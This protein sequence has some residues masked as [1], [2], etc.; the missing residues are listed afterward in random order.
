[1]TVTHLEIPPRFGAHRPSLF[2]K[3]L[4]DAIADALTQ[5]FPHGRRSAVRQVFKLSDDEARG[6]LRGSLSWETFDKVLDEGGWALA[7]EVL[8]LRFGEGLDQ[9]LERERRRHAERAEQIGEV[10]RDFRS[11]VRG[12]LGHVGGDHLRMASDLGA[13]HGDVG[14]RPKA[15]TRSD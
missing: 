4:R 14:E 10:V 9:H 12:G 2:R 6:A 13:E 3:R 7:L 5:R 1:M 11:A 8:A 15:R